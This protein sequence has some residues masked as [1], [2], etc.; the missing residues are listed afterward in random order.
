MRIYDI[1]RTETVYTVKDG[2]ALPL[3]ARGLGTTAANVAAHNDMTE[4][5][6]GGDKLFV[7]HLGLAVYTV[8]PMDTLER[9]AAS[10]GVAPSA[11]IALNRLTERLYIGQRLLIPDK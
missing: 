4:T 8:R 7:P 5:L 9:I 10:H 11:V 2:D 3:I 6:A 1:I